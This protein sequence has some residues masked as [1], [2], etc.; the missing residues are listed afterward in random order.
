[1]KVTY[2]MEH[3]VLPVVYGQIVQPALLEVELDRLTAERWRIEGVSGYLIILQ[4]TVE[5]GIER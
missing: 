3:K 2:K 5:A 4:R 1:M